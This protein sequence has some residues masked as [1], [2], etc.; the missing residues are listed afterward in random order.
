MA[1]RAAEA[2]PAAGKGHPPLE[3]GVQHGHQARGF[4]QLSDKLVSF[5]V[6]LQSKRRSNKETS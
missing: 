3:L 4:L 1:P 2:A 6:Q 5:A